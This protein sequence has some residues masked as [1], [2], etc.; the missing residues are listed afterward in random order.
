ME[1]I[2]VIALGIGGIIATAIIHEIR[3]YAAARIRSQ[4]VQM[5]Q[6]S[7]KNQV[8]DFFTGLTIARN[9]LVHMRADLKAKNATSEQLQGIERNI[10]YMDLALNNRW[11]LELAW[12]IAQPLIKTGIKAVT[13]SLE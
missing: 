6:E 1:W 9:E 8:S 11:V 13:R 4:A 3:V 2:E 10:K 5:R 7:R 12:P